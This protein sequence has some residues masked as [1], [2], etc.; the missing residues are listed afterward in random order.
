MMPNEQQEAAD[1]AADILINSSLVRIDAELYQAA[2]QVLRRR[3]EATRAQGRQEKP[4]NADN[5]R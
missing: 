1:I 3:A 5:E 4:D 2:K